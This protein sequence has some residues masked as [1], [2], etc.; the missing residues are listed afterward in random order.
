MGDCF[1]F[2]RCREIMRCEQ[3]LVTHLNKIK[4]LA[5]LKLSHSLA[6]PLLALNYRIFKTPMTN[7]ISPTITVSQVAS[8]FGDTKQ[9][10]LAINDKNHVT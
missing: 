3:P 5:S 4:Q 1:P 9:I 2:P 10:A 8:G 6:R 7:E